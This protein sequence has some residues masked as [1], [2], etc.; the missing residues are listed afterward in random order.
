MDFS[1]VV[2]KTGTGIVR[3]EG[4]RSRS[5]SGVVWGPSR[6]VTVA[7][8][9]DRETDIGVGLEG[10]EYKARLKGR[11][12]GTDLAL[13][14][15]DGALP[16]PQV[17]DGAGVK[18]GQPVVLLARPGETVRATSGIIQARGN[19]PWRTARGGEIDR[20]L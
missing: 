13:L 17:D 1:S 2:E 5:S 15:I 19:K 11:D 6:V 9:I 12:V 3:V 4:R 10:V 16:V 18:V 14:E 20:Y 7:H 8:A